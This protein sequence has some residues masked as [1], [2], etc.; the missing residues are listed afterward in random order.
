MTRRGI[1]HVLAPYDLSLF[2]YVPHRFIGIVDQILYE[3]P[4]RILPD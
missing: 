3:R 1:Q 4:G 2:G